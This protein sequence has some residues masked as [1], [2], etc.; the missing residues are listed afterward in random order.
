M[1][2]PV[3]PLARKEHP[4]VGWLVN[5]D[6]IVEAGDPFLNDA[7]LRFKK[8]PTGLT[9]SELLSSFNY[10][11]EDALQGFDGIGPVLAKNILEHRVKIQYFVSLEELLNVAQVGNFRFTKLVGRKPLTKHFALHSLMRIPYQE[12]I[13]LKQLSPWKNPAPNI[14][15]VMLLT[16]LAAKS[17]QAQHSNEVLIVLRIGTNR[18]VFNCTRP[19]EGSRANY[20]LKKLPR[21]LRSINHERS[22]SPTN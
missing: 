18:L 2:R 13:S 19:P 17:Y 8:T 10:L 11:D 9:E 5:G 12:N 1:F 15:E 7:K 3:L 4:R 21:I 6:Q 14:H 16:K 22:L 20:T